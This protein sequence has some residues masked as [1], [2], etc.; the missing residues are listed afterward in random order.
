M[1]IDLCVC[2]VVYDAIIDYNYVDN[3]QSFYYDMTRSRL[4]CQCFARLCNFISVETLTFSS[5]QYEVGTT[6]LFLAIRKRSPL[7][8]TQT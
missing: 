8:A 1:N 4:H 3:M 6:P 5:T 2:L 7:V